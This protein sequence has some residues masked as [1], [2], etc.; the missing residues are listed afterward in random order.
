[1]F[2]EIDN[3]FGGLQAVLNWFKDF[4][5]SRESVDK[6]NYIFYKKD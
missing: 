6:L 1:M 4:G 2:V 3:A 5:Y